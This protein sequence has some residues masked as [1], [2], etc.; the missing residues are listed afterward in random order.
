MI[1][2]NFPSNLSEI[3]SNFLNVNELKTKEIIK[4][5]LDEDLGPAG[6]ITTDSL[7]KNEKGKGEVKCKTAGAVLA[8]VEFAEAVF[9]EIDQDLLISK[10]HEDGQVLEAGEI[11]IAVTGGVGAMLKAERT[12]LNFLQHLSS[13]STNVRRYH[14][15]VSDLPVKITDTRKTCPGLRMLEKYAVR[16]GGGRNHRFSLSDMAMLKDNHIDNFGSIGEAVNCLRERVGHEATIEVETRNLDEVA[17][18]VDAG[19]DVIM[20]DNMSINNL[21]KAVG[22]IGHRAIVEASGNITADNLRQIAESGV[23]II[24]M[25]ALTRQWEP[26]DFSFKV[27]PI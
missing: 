19:A 27:Q 26:V 20:L 5:A 10:N 1:E 12:A 13:I 4:S 17:E 7:F 15:M 23:D 9:R 2:K 22:L 25:G 16:V 21:R 8:G 18:A 11:V 6:D 14:D 3:V 24:S